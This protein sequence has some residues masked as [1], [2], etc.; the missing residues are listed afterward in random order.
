MIYQTTTGRYTQYPTTRKAARR[1]KAKRYDSGALCPVCLER[2]GSTTYVRFTINDECIHCCRLA[3]H[4][5]YNAAPE[6]KGDDF[7]WTTEM[8]AKAG[9]VG[10]RTLDH[11]CCECLVEHPTIQDEYPDLIIDSETAHSLGFK[12]FRTGAECK[13]GHRSYRYLSTGG[14]ITCKKLK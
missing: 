14:C 11:G 9:H 7:Y 2:N 5:A 3:A 1:K 12:V 4:A 10:K 6:L 13:R 8:C